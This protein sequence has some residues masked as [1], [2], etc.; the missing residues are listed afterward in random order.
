[1]TDQVDLNI[2]NGLIVAND[3]RFRGSISVHQGKILAIGDRQVLPEARETIDAEGFLVIPGLVDPHFHSRVPGFPNRE[4]FRTASMA[5]A[6]GGVT[7]FLDMPNSVPPVN[8]VEVMRE[9]IEIGERES[10]V[11]FG[12]IAG[13]GSDNLNQIPLLSKEGVVGFKTFMHAPPEGRESEF[14]GL[15]AE[16]DGV[17]LDV[18]K[19]IAQSDSISLIHAENAQ[20]TQYLMDNLKSK[21]LRSTEAFFMSR[22]PLAEI[23]AVSRT[24]CFAEET[25]VALHLC[26]ISTGGAMGIISRWKDRGL[27]V[28]A[29]TCP[30][31]LVLTQ[32]DVQHLGPYAKGHPPI[33][34]RKDVEELWE[35]IS[36]GCVDVVGSDHCPYELKEKEVGWDDIWLAPAGTPH[37]ELML[38]LMLDQA[39][40]GRITIEKMVAILS[41]N[42]VKRFHLYP[43]KGAIQVGSDADL[44]LIDPKAKRKVSRKQMFTKAKETA[45]L[46]EGREVQGWPFMTIV[47]GKVIMRDGKIA[48]NAFGWGRFVGPDH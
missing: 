6:A 19:E 11:D 39:N 4:D 47:R 17:L 44:V 30:H 48:E 36:N 8:S 34:G 25:K 13:A 41:E 18:L 7:T 12:I 32:E 21:G 23:E 2:Q 27:N 29:E 16:N 14:K 37:V 40:R 20:I 1:M 43:R 28:S 24:L 22:P 38:P 42:A 15:C 33:R 45:R 31:Y 5:A 26:H 9:K 46:Y 3:R 10:C 35:Y